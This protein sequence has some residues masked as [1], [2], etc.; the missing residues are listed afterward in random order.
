ML[1]KVLDLYSFKNLPKTGANS[2]LRS[3]AVRTFVGACCT[4]TS[5][6]VYGFFYIVWLRP[7]TNNALQQ[8]D[9]SDGS[10][11]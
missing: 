9:G 4:L 11:R 1:T 8:F 5:S 3:V 2:R 6:I 7:E 10:Q